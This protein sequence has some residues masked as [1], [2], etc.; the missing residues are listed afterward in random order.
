MR[1]SRWIDVGLEE[2]AVKD[3]GRRSDSDR[4]HVAAGDEV[5]APELEAEEG[6]P[7][8]I[9]RRMC[10]ASVRFG[11]EREPSRSHC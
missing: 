1:L 9:P 2:D 6:R 7:G 10:L 5:P 4:T 8:G 11:R 3:P